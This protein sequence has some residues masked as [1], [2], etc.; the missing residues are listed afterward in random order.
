MRP[1]PLHLLG[2]AYADE[3][4]VYASLM[5][6]GN[7]KDVAKATHRAIERGYRY[8]KLHEIGLD[9]IRAA[10]KAA[11]NRAK[12][13]LDT[14]CPWTVAKRSQKAGNWRLG[15]ILARGTDMA[16][17]KLSRTCAS[18]VSKAYIALPQAKMP[19]ACTTSWR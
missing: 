1:A 14:N 9:E 15:L 4:E 5:R 16:T 18:F 2:G 17:G 8:I 12:V 3:L 6:Y 7:V 19:A 11:G 13:M 10:V